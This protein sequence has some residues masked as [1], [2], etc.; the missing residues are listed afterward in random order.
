MNFGIMWLFKLLSNKYFRKVAF[1]ILIIYSL[2]YSQNIEQQSSKY[3]LSSLL[4][5]GCGQML[6]GHPVK[7]ATYLFTE[8]IL[9]TMAYYENKDRTISYLNSWGNTQ[10]S[11]KQFES[12]L[13][14]LIGTNDSAIIVDSASIDELEKSINRLKVSEVFNKGDYLNSIQLRNLYFFWAGGLYIYNIFDAIEIA[15]RKHHPV[16]GKRSPAIAVWS[17]L[18][19]PGLGQIYNG[20]Y[21]K[22]G[23][24]F[25]AQTSFAASAIYRHRLMNYYQEKIDAP[26]KFFYTDSS[27]AN[28]RITELEDRR[29]HY[30]RCRN[31]FIWY[32]LGFYFYNVFDALVDAHLHDFDDQQKIT[33]RIYPNPVKESFFIKSSIK[34]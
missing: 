29:N 22:A 9:G 17:S 4:I 21:S 31:S 2:I 6:Y 19:F 33:L 8:G 12:E 27:K 20:S 3:L 28:S 23:M 1:N 11:T 26:P 18:L 30:R 5:P 25:M 24:I 34:F 10:D 14:R 32:S 13:K 15:A 16:S 7:G